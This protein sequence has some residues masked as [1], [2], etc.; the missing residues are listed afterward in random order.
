[1]QRS[2]RNR[3]LRDKILGTFVTD[4]RQSSFFQIDFKSTI[5]DCIKALDGRLIK[6]IVCYGLGSFSN[7]VELN[8]RYQLA[9]LL[10][11]HEHLVELDHPVEPVIEVYDPSFDSVDSE[12]LLSFTN[13]KFSLIEENESCARSLGGEAPCSSESL[14]DKPRCTLFYMP[15]LDKYLYNN[16]LGINW[17]NEQLAR[18]VILG[19]S[20]REMIHNEPL[21]SCKLQ[22]FY[23]YQLVH[24]FKENS[25]KD[26]G[27]SKRKRRKSNPSG[28]QEIR[29]SSTTITK[30]INVSTTTEALIEHSIN[31][32][33][34]DHF[35]IFN[36]L[37]FH[38]INGQWL[39]NNKLTIQQHR[40]PSW[41]QMTYSPPT[42]QQEQ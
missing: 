38:I 33:S 27:G 19:N 24:N 20:F 14:L 40:L 17:T 8:S 32:Q 25:N 41:S 11:L 31:D 26:S 35:G 42:D 3:K 37:S 39:D 21:S 6:K 15:H 29:T 10:L 16:L 22:L 30:A 28:F 34:F 12:T 7:G 18:L 2:K 1:M 36:S 4:L 13:P 9:L 23:M 5:N